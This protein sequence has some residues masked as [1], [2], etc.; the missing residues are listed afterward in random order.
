MLIGSEC[1]WHIKAGEHNVI[2]LVGE[3]LERGRRENQVVEN[4]IY[5]RERDTFS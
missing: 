1:K 4:L 2:D 5:G 3:K